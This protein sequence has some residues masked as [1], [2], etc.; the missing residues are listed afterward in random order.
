MG[1][2]G[3]TRTSR[4]HIPKTK[5][6]TSQTP[7][8]KIPPNPDNSSAGKPSG[9]N[10]LLAGAAAAVVTTTVLNRKPEQFSNGGGNSNFSRCLE[11]QQEFN[12]CLNRNQIN[13]EHCQHNYD[14]LLRCLNNNS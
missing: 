3:R 6:P 13:I 8:T 5:I 9:I 12:E 1:R 14:L 2:K 11:Q 4:S 7:K 10:P